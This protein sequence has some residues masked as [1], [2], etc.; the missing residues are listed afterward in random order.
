MN[1]NRIII[2]RINHRR[3]KDLLGGPQLMATR[4]FI[5]PYYNKTRN[6]GCRFKCNVHYTRDTEEIGRFFVTKK[7]EKNIYSCF[8]FTCCALSELI[9][10][11]ETNC[12]LTILRWYYHPLRNNRCRIRHI[13]IWKIWVTIYDKS[14][15]LHR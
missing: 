15:S 2:I 3:Y 6:D 11:S 5:R 12:L 7:K 9:L 1:R 4:F 10:T 13:I 14:Y 8:E